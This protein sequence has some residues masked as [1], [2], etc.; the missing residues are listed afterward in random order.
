M[1]TWDVNEAWTEDRETCFAAATLCKLL[2][3]GLMLNH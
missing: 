1:Y 3:L 2:I